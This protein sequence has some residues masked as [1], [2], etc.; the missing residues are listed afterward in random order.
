MVLDSIQKEGI[1]T[2]LDLPQGGFRVAVAW[3]PLCRGISFEVPLLILT[4]E[5]DDWAPTAL[6]TKMVTAARSR[7][8]AV[9]LKVYP[10][11]HHAFDV[12]F[13]APYYY[14]GHVMDYHPQA[15]KAATDELKRFLDQHLRS[16]AA[17]QRTSK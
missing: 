5:K 16:T 7:S 13:Y 6:C 8:T 2:A 15:A 9:I 1:Q 11:A 3:Y 12:P 14:L 4:G 10:G 17:D